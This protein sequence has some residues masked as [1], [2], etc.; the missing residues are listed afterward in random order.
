[1]RTLLVS[2]AL[3]ISFAAEQAKADFYL[4]CPSPGVITNAPPGTNGYTP[5]CKNGSTNVQW[6]PSDTTSGWPELTGDQGAAIGGAI[7]L[8]WALAWALR[9]VLRSMN[10]L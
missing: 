10:L 3:L 1:M 6:V 8:L 5:L 2:F 7:A 4:I 9:T